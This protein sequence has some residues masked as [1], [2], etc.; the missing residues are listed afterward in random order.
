MICFIGIINIIIVSMS[1]KKHWSISKDL[2]EKTKLDQ[3]FTNQNQIA[4]IFRNRDQI[5]TKKIWKINLIF[6]DE[7][8]DKWL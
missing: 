5:E 7:N 6:S 3:F 4:S 8:R 2:T 1:I